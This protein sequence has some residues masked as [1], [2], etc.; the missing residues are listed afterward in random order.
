MQ[1]DLGFSESKDVFR[2]AMH[3]RTLYHPDQVRTW[4]KNFFGPH[5]ACA[6][7]KIALEQKRKGGRFNK[8][9]TIVFLATDKRSLL[10][11]VK[12][13][14]ADVAGQVVL[15]PAPKEAE[16]FF[17]SRTALSDDARIRQF[18][19]EWVILGESGYLLG[20]SSSSF[21]MFAG[22]RIGR[23]MMGMPSPRFNICD[24]VVLVSTKSYF[25]IHY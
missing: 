25:D 12:E 5:M 22:I 16:K 4:H 19:T 23:F 24:H 21:S 1:E 17:D 20:T 15:P 10:G 11:Q 7:E 3:I 13:E 18:M 2:V 8:D 6:R 14:L 9:N